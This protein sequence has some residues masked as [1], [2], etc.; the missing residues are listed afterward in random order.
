MVRLMISVVSIDEAREAL[1]GG[2]EILDVKNPSE[3]SLGAQPPELIREISR[4][5]SAESEISA[6]IGDMPNLPGTAALAALGAA[7]CGVHYVKVGLHGAHN[8]A[9][10]V[11][12]L[13]E[14]QR[15]V[16]EFNTAVIA[17]LYADYRRAGTLNPECLPR[18][19]A[20]AGVHGCLLDTAIKDGHS[21]FEF[22]NSGALR[23]LAQQAH[24]DGL[25]FGLAGALQERDLSLANDL[26]ADVVG[27]RAAACRNNQRHGPLD[28]MR[29]KKLRERISA[30][31]NVAPPRIPA[32]HRRRRAG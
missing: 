26:G 27:L 20:K 19:A 10:A 21:L 2:A 3:G 5:F 23:A 7:S 30:S 22:T 24:A 28:A 32:P 17:A 29:V 15:A 1:Q 25:S 14:V 12:L 11:T 16:A 4:L 13:R 31:V 18:I 9:D 8:E 6:A